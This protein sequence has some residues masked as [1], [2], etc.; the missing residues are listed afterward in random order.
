MQ[1]LTKQYIEAHLK[2]LQKLTFEVA[3]Q[4][5]L[6]YDSLYDHMHA[7]FLTLGLSSED[8]GRVIDDFRGN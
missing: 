2:H 4:E 1:T 5:I 8:A 3:S 7:F 6:K